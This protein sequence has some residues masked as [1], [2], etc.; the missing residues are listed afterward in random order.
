MNPQSEHE[1][2]GIG[3]IMYSLKHSSCYKMRMHAE[4][5]GEGV[6]RNIKSALILI[7]P[8]TGPSNLN[9]KCQRVQIF[10]GVLVMACPLA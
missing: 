5:E 3:L 1:D 9:K 4:R 6:F 7:K 2:N 10:P 8:R